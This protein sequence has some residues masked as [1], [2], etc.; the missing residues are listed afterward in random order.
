[1]TGSSV[2]ILPGHLAN[3]IAAGEV[4]QRPA[5]VVKELLENSL[6]AGA[7]RV[8]IS[9]ED[10]GKAAI[11]VADNGTGMGE[12]DAVLSLERH[13]TSKIESVDDLA[14][15]LT[16]GFRGEALPSIASV[17]RLVLKTRRQRDEMAV[18]L[19]CHGGNPPLRTFEG[20]EI[21][22][23]VTVSNLFHN[24]PARRKF[25]RS[26]TTEFRQ[27]Y[28]TLQ[29]MAISRPDVGFRFI[30]E[31]K[32]VLDLEPATLSERMVDVFGDYEVSGMI[33]VDEQNDI[34]QVTGYIGKP[35][36]GRKVKPQ[37]FLFLNRRYVVSRSLNHAVFS[38]YEHL[39]I[40]SAY[41]F[42]MLQMTI[43]PSR[44]DVN[45]H[46]AK[47]EVKFE[48]EGAV[49]RFLHSLVQKSLSGTGHVPA[50][51][52]AGAG[53]EGES[54]LRFTPRQHLW[55]ERNW[56][57]R[58][59][60]GQAVAASLMVGAGE[61]DR[62]NTGAKPEDQ[63]EMHPA[64]FA[65]GPIC[66]LHRKY[67]LLQVQGG[68]M[69]VDQHVAHERVLYEQIVHRFSSGDQPGQQLLFPQTLQLSPP[70]ALVLTEMLPALEQI[71]FVVRPFGRDTFVVEC[72]PHG[73][74]EGN[75]ADVLRGILFQQRDSGTRILPDSRDVL[76]K[77]YSCKAAIKAGDALSDPE[78]RTLIGQLFATK[79]PFVCPH[80]R[81][82]VMR[83]SLE[84]LDRRFGRS[85]P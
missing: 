12:D 77:S 29:R 83:L 72:V 5:S 74:K 25:L 15:I 22:T 64:E 71:G 31:G 52:V 73:V 9:I 7:T 53:S 63:T 14:A 76:A 65:S 80:G 46:P 39:M 42:F 55:N 41:P 61:Q 69:L 2:K 48:D 10:G 75:E 66:Q 4:V 62:G 45:V 81:P 32:T 3:K 35:S 70:D 60:D 21:G 18:V 37:Q 43:D 85:L 20:R 36:F 38:A 23:I 24:I 58:Q 84:E 27:T 30:S 33:P 26:R 57:G 50:L 82:T 28:D 17:S 8:I 1:M 47:L 59:G 34:L 13:A 68:V 19:S 11:T 54:S 40:K 6:D 16:Y 67:I 78:M 79:I 51:E 44:V 49:Y 56:G